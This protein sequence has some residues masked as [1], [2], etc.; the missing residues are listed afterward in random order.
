MRITILTG[1][2][3]SRESGLQTFR[4]GDGLWAGHSIEEVATATALRRNPER[5]YDFYNS[6]R[7][8]VRRAEP[9]AAHYALAELA[10]RY[11]E[12]MIVTQN[13]D[14]LHER[15]GSP[16]VIHLH[17]EVLLARHVDD[18]DYRVAVPGDLH[19]GDLSSVG[20]R[21]RP[22]ICLFEETPFE[23][24]RAV[25]FAQRADVFAVIGTSLNVYPAAGLLDLTRASSVTLI[26]PN[27]PSVP[28][29]VQVIAEPAT[30]GVPRWVQTL[31]GGE[32]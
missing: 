32:G 15:A 27:P 12:T 29:R 30:T 11:P 26:D 18:P 16:Q 24:D 6:R 1:A 31:L 8:E 10:K 25:R 23:W 9:N 3:I 2:G 28:S 21:L 20:K 4:D 14:D 17:G 5:V 7:A 22:H 19:F 13:V